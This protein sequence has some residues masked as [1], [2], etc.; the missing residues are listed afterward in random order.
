MQHLNEAIV[1]QVLIEAGRGFQIEKG[2]IGYITRATSRKRLVAE[3]VVLGVVCV[4]LG[5]TVIGSVIIIAL[6]VRKR[7]NL[8][9]KSWWV[10]LVRIVWQKVGCISC[11][12]IC[13]HHVAITA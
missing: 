12:G 11:A 1:G 3:L 2:G 7:R 9:S 10:L 8:T 4:L 13:K 6:L 5:V